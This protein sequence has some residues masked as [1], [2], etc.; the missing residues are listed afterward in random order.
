MV[1]NTEKFQLIF[2]GLKEDHKLSI[3]I[4]GNVINMSDAEKLLGV[5][6][7]SKLR[8]N[9]HIKIICQ[10][11]NNKVKG[12]SKVVPE[13]E[14][15]KARILYTSIILTN[16][17]Y[18]PLIW[19]FCGRTINNIVNSIQYCALRVLLNDYD[20]SFQELLHRNEK[21][22]IHETISKILCCKYTDV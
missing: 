21:V 15:Q 9:E 5:T 16:F 3:E 22:T 6:I 2:F 4:N 12:F 7:D 19:M 17:N 20:Y 1:A 13:L 18:C 8:F 10:K 11:I 14:P